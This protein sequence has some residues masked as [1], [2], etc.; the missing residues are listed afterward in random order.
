MTKPTGVR[1]IIEGLQL[2]TGEMKVSS[3]TYTYDGVAEFMYIDAVS[4]QDFDKV[5][6]I[7]LELERQRDLLLL[8]K[9]MFTKEKWKNDLLKIAK[10]EA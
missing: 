3:G 4:L 8:G 6:A 2:W 9:P 7:A 10:G 5:V 1:E